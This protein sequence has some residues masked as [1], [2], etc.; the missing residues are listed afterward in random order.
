MFQNMLD[1]GQV[2]LPAERIRVSQIQK[3][4]CWGDQG[5]VLPVGIVVEGR[6][7]IL[8]G[9][10]DHAGPFGVEIDIKHDLQVVEIALNDG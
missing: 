9:M 1:H 10:G 5:I 2:I 4:R 8:L 6:P 7:G 3:A